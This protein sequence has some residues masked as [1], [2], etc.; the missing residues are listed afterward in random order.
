[1]LALTKRGD[2]LEFD[3]TGTD[4]NV[5]MINC[6]RAGAVGGSMVAILPLLCYDI[7]WALGGLHR[8]IDFVTPV[9]T[10]INAE[11]PHGVSMGSIAGTWSATNAANVCI[12]RD[13][14]QRA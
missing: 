14:L 7:P 4:P 2:E 5:G 1:M 12:A 8:A 9:G 6:T 3:F 11:F 13:A 10:I